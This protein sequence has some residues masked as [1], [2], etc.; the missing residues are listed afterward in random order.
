MEVNKI[1]NEDC[2]VTL[3]GWKKCAKWVVKEM[4][5]KDDN[6]RT[7]SNHDLIYAVVGKIF[8]YSK[9]INKEE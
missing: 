8:E 4:C 6:T 5:I 7:M 3:G 1:Y 2:L 9:M